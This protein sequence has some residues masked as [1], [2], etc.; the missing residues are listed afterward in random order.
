MIVDDEYICIND[1]HSTKVGD[2]LSVIRVVHDRLCLSNDKIATF[3]EMYKLSNHFISYK[4]YLR[5]QKL[6]KLLDKPPI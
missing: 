2:I 3:I 6:N 5:K 4:L 1:Y